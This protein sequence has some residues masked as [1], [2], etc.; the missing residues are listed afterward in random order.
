[1]KRRCFY[2]II[3]LVFSIVFTQCNSIDSDHVIHNDRD[4][5]GMSMIINETLPEQ[6]TALSEKEKLSRIVLDEKAKLHQELKEE[7]LEDP[8]FV[9]KNGQPPEH[10]LD[11]CT[12]VNSIESLCSKMSGNMED[13][14]AIQE[15]I[16]TLEQRI[17]D[18]DPDN[19]C[20]LYD[21]C[22]RLSE[23]EFGLRAYYMGKNSPYKE[24]IDESNKDYYP[25]LAE[26]YI[27]SA[28]PQGM[29]WY[30]L[31]D[32]CISGCVVAEGTEER[33]LY[34]FYTSE[35][36]EKELSL[37]GKDH[38]DDCYYIIEVTECFWGDYEQGELVAFAPRSLGAELK[39]DL[40]KGEEWFFFLGKDGEQYHITYNGKD[41][42][43]LSTR[44]PA[45]FRI[46]GG[47]VSSISR[48]RDFTQYNGETPEELALDM[49]RIREKYRYMV[50]GNV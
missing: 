40:K 10:Y 19:A 6:N 38:F 28:W 24:G 8:A 49:L 50:L 3:I 2:P 20:F 36:V 48:Y 12:I 39:E 26:A 1:M 22:I 32:C 5:N 34:D 23:T 16:N 4:V 46:T 27:S 45:I 29:I 33:S 44:T 9:R 43:T 14:A 30:A 21:E 42:P 18:I 7:I 35:E 37:G 41:Y 47:K 11:Y 17:K 25:D 13:D 15:E 31:S